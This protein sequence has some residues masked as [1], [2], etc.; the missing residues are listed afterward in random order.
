MVGKFNATLVLLMICAW[1]AKSQMDPLLS[2]LK[3]THT[4]QCVIQKQGKT[5]LHYTKDGG[6]AR[7]L[8]AFSITKSIVGLAIGC[9][10][11]ENLIEL[12]E[13]VH[14]FFPE[15]NQG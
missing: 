2:E 12:D 11:D 3:K 15:L 8:A 7:A 1:S 5:I 13:P 9:L 6:N 14:K 10:L 4:T